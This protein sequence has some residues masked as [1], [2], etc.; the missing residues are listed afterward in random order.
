MYIYIHNISLLLFPDV[1]DVDRREK[2]VP[3][4]PSFLGGHCC[5]VGSFII[6]KGYE[7]ELFDT[8]LQ[9]HV[10]VPQGKIHNICVCYIYPLPS[11]QRF[12]RQ[13]ASYQR[14]MGDQ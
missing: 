2:L 12:Y 7:E 5:Y 6:N 14:G 13:I 3:C 10:R 11:N 4:S 9:L 8:E 1:D